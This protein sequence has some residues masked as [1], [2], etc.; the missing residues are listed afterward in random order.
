MQS[1]DAR[2]GPFDLLLPLG[3]GGVADVWLARP[4]G[5]P[6]GTELV[7]KRLRPRVHRDLRVLEMFEREA[8][9]GASVDHPGMIRTLGFCAIDN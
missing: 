7:V 8:A 5:E 4:T 3:R 1:P 6:V 2:F 9:V